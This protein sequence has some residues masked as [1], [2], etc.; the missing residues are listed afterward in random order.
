[1]RLMPVNQRARIH[2]LQ[3]GCV[4]L[5]AAF[6][7]TQPVFVGRAHELIEMTGI[8]LVIICIAGR[9]WSCLYIGSR[10]NREL[11]TTGPYSI[12]RNPLYLFSTIGAAGIGLMF[13]SIAAT[14]GLGLLAYGI[15]S[16]P[17]TRKPR[18]CRRSS[19]P[20]TTLMRGKRHYSGPSLPF[21]A[22]KQK[23]GFHPRR[24][25]APSLTACS[26]SRFFP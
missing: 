17:P 3:A 24:C 18:T 16:S 5:A 12:T 21:I 11:V 13:G 15:S 8:G 19:G 25:G 26:S 4:V 14:L 6:M 23:W 20:S 2:L 10:K 22:I 9:M 1:M 7:L